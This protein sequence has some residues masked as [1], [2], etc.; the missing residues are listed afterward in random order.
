MN[1]SMFSCSRFLTIEK[2]NTMS[3]SAQERRR[4]EELVVAKSK[5]ASLTSRSL[6][7]N[8]TPTVGLRYVIQSYSL[9]NY[10]L[11]WNSDFTSTEKSGRDRNENSASSSQVWHRARDESAFEHWETGARSTRSTDS[12][13]EGKVEPPQSRDI[14]YLIHRESLRECSTKV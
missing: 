11:V 13:Y 2:P 1:F 7:A 6:S 9:E 8:Q 14:Q 4:G 12:T 3:K 5:P 10:R